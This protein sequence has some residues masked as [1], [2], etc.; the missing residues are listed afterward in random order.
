VVGQPHR[1]ILCQLQRVHG[2]R[3]CRTR[4]AIDHELGL[5]ADN[6]RARAWILAAREGQIHDGVLRY[7]RPQAVPD[8]ADR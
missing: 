5:P 4:I 7:M 3:G 2:K 6:L 8:A 1:L